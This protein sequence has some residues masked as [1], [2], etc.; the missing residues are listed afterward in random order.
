[1]KDVA[2]AIFAVSRVVLAVL[3]NRGEVPVGRASKGDIVV[4]FVVADH[5]LVKSFLLVDF[6]CSQQDDRH[7]VA[8]HSK[9]YY[10]YVLCIL[11]TLEV[12]RPSYILC[13]QVLC[14]PR[15]STHQF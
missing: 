1:V 4:V 8:V 5:M 12:V 13:T 9:M 14:L 6:P 2:K 10:P 11:S 15:R 7:R 3:V